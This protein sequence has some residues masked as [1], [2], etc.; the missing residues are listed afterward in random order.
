MNIK[1]LKNI[2]DKAKECEADAVK[3]DIEEFASAVAWI[4]NHESLPNE[5]ADRLAEQS[6]QQGRADEG[7]NK[8][9]EIIYKIISIY[10]NKGILVSNIDFSFEYGGIYLYITYAYHNKFIKK[11]HYI[12]G[13]VLSKNNADNSQLDIILENELNSV[14]KEFGLKGEENEV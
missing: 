5:Y 12:S 11:M 10:E 6:Y 3:V 9:H 4:E 7:R 1:Y 13:G 8:M 14:I 2:L